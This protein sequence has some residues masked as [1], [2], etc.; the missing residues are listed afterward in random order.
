MSLRPGF[1][2]SSVVL[3]L[4]LTLPVVLCSWVSQ[5][6]SIRRMGNIGFPKLTFIVMGNAAKAGLGYCIVRVCSVEL[7]CVE[8][9]RWLHMLP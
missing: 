9:D 2:V 5:G 3:S 6:M 4:V 7:V 8:V 1:A